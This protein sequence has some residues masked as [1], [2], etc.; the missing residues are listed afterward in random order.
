ME[1]PQKELIVKYTCSLCGTTGLKSR[2][3][4]GT[5]CGRMHPGITLEAREA[6]WKASELEFKTRHHAELAAQ[7]EVSQVPSETKPKPKVTKRGS[8]PAVK[9]LQLNETIPARRLEDLDAVKMVK[10]NETIPARRLEDLDADQVPAV[11][12][13]VSKPKLTPVPDVPEVPDEPQPLQGVLAVP[14]GSQLLIDGQIYYQPEPDAD[15]LQIRVERVLMT[16]GLRQATSDGRT[17]VYCKVDGVVYGMDERLILNGT[18]K[19]I[20]LPP[21]SAVPDVPPT[22]SA[23]VE[24]PPQNIEYRDG[25][26]GFKNA[27]I[28]YHQVKQ[29]EADLKKLLKKA[30]EDHYDHIRDFTKAHGS[31]SAKDKQDFALREGGYLSWLV[32]TPGRLQTKYNQPAIA[33]WCIENGHDAVLYRDVDLQAWEKL[34]ETG[35]VPESVTE[36]YE[37]KIDV[38]D[39]FRLMLTRE[40]EDEQ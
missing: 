35:V 23:E 21:P 13:K 8:K 24:E 2:K 26:P 5:H 27:V 25:L 7:Q 29:Q 39:T 1:K 31:E 17:W 12:K 10:F 16:V 9:T 32:R 6:A 20:S 22:A 33:Q 40:T 4:F 14:V 30:H 37:T 38:P 15:Y 19:L 18:H 34:K 3:G 36:L 28:E 11:T